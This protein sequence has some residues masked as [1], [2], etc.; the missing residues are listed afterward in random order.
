MRTRAAA[1]S[2]SMWLPM[3]AQP[4]PSGAGQSFR[5][6]ANRLP[7]AKKMSMF[8]TQQDATPEVPGVVARATGAMM[9]G[10][11]MKSMILTSCRTYSVQLW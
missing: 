10:F 3:G 7:Q 6:V 2:N 5:W 11:Q 8:Q 4:L 1:K 9:S